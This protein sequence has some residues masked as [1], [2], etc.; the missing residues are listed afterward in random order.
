MTRLIGIAGSLRQG[1]CNAALLRNAAELTP[2]GCNL[3]IASIKD[4]PLYDGD[5]EAERGIPAA[6]AALKDRVAAVD[7]L[8]LVTPEYN[9]SIPGIFK[10][11]IDWMTRPA[12]WAQ[13]FPR[14]RGYRCCARSAPARSS[15]RPYMYPAPPRCST[16]RDGSPT[17]PC[18]SACVLTWSNSRPLSPARL[19]LQKR[20]KG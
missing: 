3:E 17:R 10:N 6:V 20:H 15:A 4:I 8:L 11:A 16:P 12:A 2:A 1:S 9:H 18:A 14:P 13:P 19:C 7:S 5:L